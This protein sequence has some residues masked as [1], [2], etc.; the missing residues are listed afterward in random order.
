M[1]EHKTISLLFILLILS[2]VFLA[3][4]ALV[5]QYVNNQAVST[6]V[7]VKE[8][9]T[10]ERAFTNLSASSAKNE[11]AVG[12]TFPITVSIDTGDNLVTIVQLELR[13]DPTLLSVVSVSQ[14]DFFV[15][16]IEYAKKIDPKTGEIQYAIGSFEGKKGQGVLATIQVIARKKTQANASIEVLTIKSTSIVAELGSEQSVLKARKGAS[17]VIR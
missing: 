5:S 17:V 9:V 2:V 4:L 6:R 13:Y 12:E 14:G 11:I 16:P 15:S 1:K 10:Q 3:M 8:T 7:P